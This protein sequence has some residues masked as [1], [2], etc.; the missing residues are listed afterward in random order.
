MWVEFVV[1]S[2]LAPRVFLQ[3]L[4]FSPLHKNQRSKFQFDQ[5][6]RPTWKPAKAAVALFLTF[7]FN[8][9]AGTTKVLHEIQLVR[10]R[11][12]WGKHNDPSCNCWTG[13]STALANKEMIQCSLRVHQLAYCPCNM[14][15]TRSYEGACP[16][17]TTRH[18]HGLSECRPLYFLSLPYSG[19]SQSDRTK[20][21]QPNH[22]Q[23]LHKNTSMNLLTVDSAIQLLMRMDWKATM[24]V[25]YAYPI[26]NLTH[27]K[28]LRYCYAL[29]SYGKW[30][31][32]Y[33]W[34]AALLKH[35]QLNSNLWLKTDVAWAIT[36]Q[37]P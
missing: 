18:H 12:S 5:H 15:P 33:M 20:V 13:M 30:L 1:G 36:L 21:T 37:W 14:N 4:Q 25:G 27:C 28:M 3:I 22:L 32:E 23:Y 16:H 34:L 10:I 2:H 29:C 24:A 26:L 8:Y 6:R 9:V 35:Y 11:R 31:H 17:F 19:S 7:S